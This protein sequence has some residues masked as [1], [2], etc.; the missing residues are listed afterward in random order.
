MRHGVRST[1]VNQ[2]CRCDECKAANR[3]YDLEARRHN[4]R[5]RARLAQ[6]TGTVDATIIHG[7]V[8]SY[9]WHGCRCEECSE[10]VRG[11][12]RAAKRQEAFIRKQRLVLGR[13]ERRSDTASTL[14]GFEERTLTRQEEA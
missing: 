6:K 5:V 14:L 13:E 9:K 12:W 11:Y 4:V 8:Q 10:A 7:N 1:Y 3:I 2:R